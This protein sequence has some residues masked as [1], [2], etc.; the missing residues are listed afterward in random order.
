MTNSLRLALLLVSVLFAF[1]CGDREAARPRC[2]VCGMFADAEGF[3]VTERGGHRFDSPKCAFQY[4]EG[5]PGAEFQFTEY[6]SGELRN[7]ADLRFVTDSDVIGPMGRDRIP[8]APEQVERFVQDH[9]G[10]V[11]ERR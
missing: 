1:A 6:Y 7:E 2:P 3:M 11:V 8:V 9:G 5:T 4:R 10:R